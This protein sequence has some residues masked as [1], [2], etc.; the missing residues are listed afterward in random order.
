MTRDNKSTWSGDKT[1]SQIANFQRIGGITQQSADDGSQ[2]EE[3]DS[4]NK[5]LVHRDRRELKD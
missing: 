5:E 2:E 1:I 4:K 3:R